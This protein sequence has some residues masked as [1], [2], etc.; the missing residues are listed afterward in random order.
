RPGSGPAGRL[1][2][3]RAPPRG[4]PAAVPRRRAATRPASRARRTHPPPGMIATVPAMTQGPDARGAR[5]H[6]TRVR[7]PVHHRRKG[8]R[9]ADMELFL[10]ILV[11]VTSLLLCVLV[12]FHKAKGGG[13]STLFGGGT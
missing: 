4:R 2:G 3:H 10:Q 1:R 12:L 7:N 6:R 11:V 13:L 5:R 8:S 9:E